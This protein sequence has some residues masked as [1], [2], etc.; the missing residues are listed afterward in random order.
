MN[1]DIGTEARNSQKRNTEIEFSLQCGSADC[2]QPHYVGNTTVTSCIHI[3]LPNSM[4]PPVILY[5]VFVH[6]KVEFM[7][8]KL[9]LDFWA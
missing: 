6:P 4:L 5:F 3:V 1:V 8:V 7:N 2:S 9:R